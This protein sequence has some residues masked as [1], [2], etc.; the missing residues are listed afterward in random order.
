MAYLLMHCVAKFKSDNDFIFAV[1]RLCHI[2]RAE[3]KDHQHHT[4]QVN[5]PTEVQAFFAD[6]AAGKYAEVLCVV[7][8]SLFDITALVHCGLDCEPS[9]I[10]GLTTDSAKV[11]A[12]DAACDKMFTFAIGIVTQRLSE[13]SLALT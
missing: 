10:I 11:L 9:D 7:I 8:E 3:V 6:Q 1:R 5:T 2:S 12:Q 13:Y 4:S